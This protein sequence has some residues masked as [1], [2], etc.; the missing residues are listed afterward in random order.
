[1]DASAIAAARVDNE[2]HILV[3]SGDRAGLVRFT[4]PLSTLGEVVTGP[5]VLLGTSGDDMLMASEVS[6]TLT[7]GDGNGILVGGT[8]MIGG[9]GAD[10]FVARYAPGLLRI[11]DFA[12]GTD[13]LDLSD[14][15]IL[16]DPEQL[17]L[18]TTATGAR[19]K[20][21]DSVIEITSASRAP[22]SAKALLGPAFDLPD[23]VLVLGAQSGI[24]MRGT[25]AGEFL[26]GIER[27]DTIT[28]E[29]G[30]D[31]LWAR[32]GDGNGSMGGFTVDD[33]L[34]G[35]SGVDELWGS[36]GLD[37]L[38]G[39]NGDDLLFDGTGR[40]CSAS[41]PTPATIRSPISNWA[42]TRSGFTT[43]PCRSV[44]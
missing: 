4:V 40:M 42:P 29:G 14:F 17:D 1:M 6:G 39:S 10:I 44:P 8:M 16:R 36:V 15:P 9:A 35:E 38:Y 18:R 31:S 12:P 3:A 26:Y 27:A 11:A 43:P 30:V 20:W 41:P 28:G 25:P 13:R 19:I 24:Q 5:G 23:R 32:G 21:R 33:A 7:A 22:I 37:M 34:H 2:I